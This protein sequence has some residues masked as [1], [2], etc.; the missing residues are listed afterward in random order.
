MTPIAL[1]QAGTTSL[2]AYR[3]TPLWEDAE[4]VLSRATH[5]GAPPVLVLAPTNAQRAVPGR[6]PLERAYS[7]RGELQSSWAACPTALVEHEGR[8]TLI[9][10]DPGGD[11][12]ASKVGAPWSI[13]PFLRVAI[14]ITSALRQLHGRGLVHKDVKP[15]NIF[16]SEARGE[17]WL[18]GFGITSPLARERQM[19]EAPEVIAGTLAYMAPEQ[20]GR[21]NRSIDSRSDLYSLG[22]TLYELLAGRLPFTATDPMGW[23]HCHVAR[24]PAPL[25]NK[26]SI[27]P[28][29][30]SDIVMKLLAKTAEDRYQTAA[31]V[32]HDLRRALS[33]WE[34]TGQI[35][36][37]VL[38]THDLSDR[39]LLPE[40]LYGRGAEIETLLSSFDRVLTHRDT[41]LV[42]V[43]GYSGIGKSS[44][45]NELH[46]VLVP[47]RGLYA[48]GKF[49]QY[50]RDIPYGTLAQ[51]FV[52]LIRHVLG[53]SEGEIAVWREELTRALGSNGQL[54]A[55]LVPELELVIGKQPAIAELPPKEAQSRFQ[56]AVRRFLGV[57]ARAEHP[58]ALFLDDLQWLDAATLELL[59]HLVGNP[60]VRHLLV[61]GAYRDNEVG[62]THPLAHTLDKLRK[63]SE[64]VSE[65]VLTPLAVGD[66]AALCADGLHA[67][68]AAVR[69]LAQL[70][71]E[72]TGGNPFFAIQFISA[73]VDER[74]LVFAPESASWLWDIDA[75]RAKGF[76]DNVVELMA[77]KIHRLSE[78]TKS[79]LRQFACL[80]NTARVATL[81]MVYGTPEAGIHRALSEAVSAGLI[82][83][84]GGGYSF[85]HDR[86]HEAAY[87]TIPEGERV[88]EHLR[89]GRLLAARTP[90]DDLEENVFE[91]LNHLNRGA[92]LI[93]SQDE[94][95]RVAE[96]NY[97][98]A[99]RAKASTAHAAARGYAELGQS[100]LGPGAWERKFRLM[101]NLDLLL[102]NCEF[103]MTELVATE[104][105]LEK[106]GARATNLTDRAAVIFV[107][108]NLF[109]ALVD[110]ADRAVEICLDYLR[111]V[112]ID[113]W[114]AHPSDEMVQREY[115]TLLERLDGRSIDDL[116]KLP[117]STDPDVA[118]TNE[119]LLGMFTPAFNTDRRLMALILLRMGNLGL[120]Y[121]NTDA[122][123]LG[124]AFLGM[125][126]GSAFGDYRTGYLFGKLARDLV[127]QRG[128]VRYSGRIYHTLGTHVLCW[129]QHVS[130][131][132]A[133]FRRALP[134]MQEVG[135]V[136]YVSFGYIGLTTHL[137]ASGEPL[138]RVQTAT[139]NALAIVRQ[140]RFE[141]ATDACI[142]QLRL[143]RALR[144]QLAD[145]CSLED[146]RS[147]VNDH[148]GLDMSRGWF[149]IRVMQACFF[150]GDYAAG[151]T[152]AKRAEPYIPLS[153]SFF[154]LVEYHFYAALVF[155]ASFDTASP[156]EREAHRAVIDAHRR[157]LAVWL[158]H[159]PEN[160]ANRVALIDA[161]VARIE[162]RTLDAMECYE[163]A[164][165]SSHENGFVHN[166]ALAFEVAAR[167]YAARGFEAIGDTYLEKAR[168]RYRTWGAD[169]KV[170]HIEHMHPR[171]RVKQAR[172]AE[173]QLENID[174]ATVVKTSQAV[175]LQV[176][177]ERLIESLM[178]IVLQHAG[179][180]RGLL[181]LAR[182]D[183][184]WI[185]AEA[186]TTRD[187]VSVRLHH[188]AVAG[189]EIAESVLQ[190]AVRS[191]ETVLISD[192][193]VTNQFSSDPYL[194]RRGCRSVLCLPLVKQTAVIGALYLEN[195]L[196]PRVF[197]PSRVEVLKLLAS[198][199]AIS[200]ENASL[201]EKEALLKEV[202][203]RVKNN[204]QLISSMLNLQASRIKD[205]A[206]AELFADSR[207]RVR[208]MALV[209]E[210]LYRAGNFS[211]IPMESHIKAL[212]AQL[213]RAYGVP[214]QRVGLEVEIADLQLDMNR[215][216]TCGLIV[217]ELVSNALKHAF[218]H[219]RPGRIRITVEPQGDGR[220]ALR[221][222]D[223]GVGLAETFDFERADTLG[224]QLVSDLTHQLRGTIE[225]N[226]EQGTTFTIVF[227]EATPTC[228]A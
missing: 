84:A 208:S 118:A 67:E 72:K 200:L 215:A 225:V 29:A 156:D 193:Q 164:I 93:E 113:D 40:K 74:L 60:D 217:N 96:L 8:P 224:L 165:R 86:V 222:H 26:A 127:E 104:E 221:V 197:T 41:Q 226:R 73:L 48:S 32:E 24:Q 141:I 227:D 128:L 195:N 132:V 88:G 155:A 62:P 103:V 189:S 63:D 95:D 183:G 16:V 108:T 45:V 2:T 56:A 228:R 207:N 12:L 158:E 43:S 11:L 181:L 5:A 17:V 81:S 124:F 179:A 184:L 168:D 34:S 138:D 171:L 61:V 64:R 87:A 216:V 80:G 15:S 59:E 78:T 191:R 220:H 157:E 122:S 107:Q 66:I 52:V 160:I 53:R 22:I 37:F 79:A 9:S 131:A 102:A 46:R 190:F 70:V 20:T 178:V 210:N 54:I 135:D 21:M 99:E 98:A 211:K 125:V 153:S 161:E 139:E 89:I 154:E 49:D 31:G 55:N 7:L 75:I 145:P 206:V 180:E 69:P 186:T 162:G 175:S 10:E 133:S 27:V 120:Q 112:G 71:H 106:L 13:G 182:N 83:R 134:L 28:R 91:I 76:T 110:R 116:W 198:Q 97:I 137:I 109:T 147:F 205:P 151:R 39:L 203:H 44:V 130:N 212:C 4:F 152:A 129:T 149:W 167:F 1:R 176:G 50:N 148:S 169:G 33:A 173:S 114:S 166:E 218:P 65:I 150:F 142:G 204:L 105:R 115:R 14:G 111:H 90:A 143:V 30:I 213:S 68:L 121:G 201:E 23:V 35:E 174:L 146:T 202:H 172:V 192:A 123:S 185:E 57:F 159:C 144:G 214:G 170:Q 51:A 6:C 92:E 136:T 82:H 117:L 194:A 36:P 126:L 223:D 219:G 100:L 187:G 58:L 163:R 47:P 18:T 177:V 119:V 140:G 188:A 38:G 196:A 101:F 3:F 19:P 209:H 94:R 77:L 199:A 85:L 25:Q 42:L